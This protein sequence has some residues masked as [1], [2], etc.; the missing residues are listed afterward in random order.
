MWEDNKP[1]ILRSRRRFAGPFINAC[2]DK[3]T[4]GAVSAKQRGRR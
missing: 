3:L 2:Q 4:V 1:Q